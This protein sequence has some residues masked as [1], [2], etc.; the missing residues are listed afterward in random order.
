M[1]FLNSENGNGKILWI[2]ISIT[3]VYL[4]KIFSLTLKTE[5]FIKNRRK[6]SYSVLKMTI[7]ELMWR[8]YG[9]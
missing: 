7:A 2:S 4:E 3:K 9:R 1:E 8:D 5:F 6:M